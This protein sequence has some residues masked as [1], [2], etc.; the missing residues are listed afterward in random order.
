M[1]GYYTNGFPYNIVTILEPG[2]AD[3]VLCI[4]C[5][6]CMN[7]C[8]STNKCGRCA[9]CGYI[10]KSYCAKCTL[11]TC[12]TCKCLFCDVYMCSCHSHC[13][14]PDMQRSNA[15]GDLSGRINEL[16][17]PSDL[18]ICMREMDISMDYD[19]EKTNNMQI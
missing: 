5:D 8:V 17:N 1:K 3:I 16:N 14:A 19:D 18:V 2:K 15:V 12:L 11:P 13:K 10:S 9:G 4:D 6:K 7:I